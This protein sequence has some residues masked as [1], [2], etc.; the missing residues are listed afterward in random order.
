MTPVSCAQCGRV[1]TEGATEPI[2]ARRP[3]PSCGSTTRNIKVLAQDGA[4]LRE[5]LGMKARRPGRSRPYFEAVC[6][7]DLH[8]K[9]GRWMHKS[10]IIDRENDLYQELVVDPGTGNVVHECREPLSAH[11]G[12]GTA[13]RSSQRK[14]S[15]GEL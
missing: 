15:R 7:A 14:R 12:H 5:K 4:I 3:C 8:R 13:R 6:G 1:I 10:R 11:R 9:T 2:K